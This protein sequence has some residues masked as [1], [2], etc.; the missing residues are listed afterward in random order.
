MS[1]CN[2]FRRCEEDN[3]L[4]SGRG[5]VDWG[6]DGGFRTGED[7]VR[8]NIDVVAGDLSRRGGVVLVL[9]RCSGRG[10]VD[11]GAVGGFR[12]GEDFVRLNID[13]VDSDL[14]CRGGVFLVL[15]RAVRTGEL[16]IRRKPLTNRLRCRAEVVLIASDTATEAISSSSSDRSLVCSGSDG[17]FEDSSSVSVTV[18]SS[19]SSS[20]SS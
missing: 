15:D 7:F 16:V 5:G 2:T 1:L 3:L 19:V 11:W 20:S 6:A 12:T 18:S 10:G 14:S 13:A 17:S 9:G 4:C 8:L